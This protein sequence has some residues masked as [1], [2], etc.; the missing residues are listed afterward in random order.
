MNKYVKTISFITM[1]LMCALPA[2]AEQ[3]NHSHQ[4]K[5]SEQHD[6]NL[7]DVAVGE[8]V[9]LPAFQYAPGKRF[10]TP[11]TMKRVNLHAPGS[12]IWLVQA[13]GSKK[14]LPQSDH[15]V[16]VSDPEKTATRMYMTV[17]PKTEHTSISVFAGDVSHRV[18]G[19]WHGDR[20]LSSKAHSVNT[21]QHDYNCMAEGHP[22]DHHTYPDLTMEDP[23][24]AEYST[25]KLN[26]L[27]EMLVDTQ[28][29]S[30]ALQTVSSKELMQA[31]VAIDTDNEFLAEKFNNDTAAAIRYLDELFAGMNTIFTRDLDVVLLRGDTYLYAPGADPYTSQNGASSATVLDE[32]TKHW[33]TDSERQGV[34]RAFVAMLSGKNASPHKASGL[35]WILKYG[36][37][38]AFTGTENPRNKRYFGHFSASQVYTYTQNADA[39]VAFVAHELGHNFGVGHTHCTQDGNGDFLDQC[40]SGEKRGTG[41]CYSGPTTCPSDMSGTSGSLMSYCHLTGSNSETG[42]QCGKVP[43]FHPVQE[44]LLAK[45]ISENV[46]NGCFTPAPAGT[47]FNIAPEKPVTPNRPPVFENNPMELTV[48]IN[49]AALTVVGVVSA[50]DPDNDTLQYRIVSS[51]AGSAFVIDANSGALTLID[52]AA[53]QSTSLIAMEIAVSDT[54]NHITKTDLLIRIANEQQDGQNRAISS[55]AEKIFTSTF[56]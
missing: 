38:C 46:T 12:N 3:H 49:T 5:S 2:F 19:T 23:E 35:A 48:D 37:Y 21:H 6:L 39:D 50:T 43:S 8:Q 15:H 1:L 41:A 34:K 7:L 31:V 20:L 10:S 17:D 25:V 16:F 30:K 51:T 29:T 24:S 47:A 53:L 18:H 26:P 52:P 13:D 56:D 40:F 44:E 32:M 28:P 42:G 54:H 22:T 9:E 27:A 55:N 11:V 45:R 36:D 4:H 33:A 14:A